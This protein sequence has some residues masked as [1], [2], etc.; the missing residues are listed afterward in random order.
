MEAVSLT[1]DLPEVI[2][3][4]KL[5]KSCLYASEIREKLL[6]ECNCTPANVPTNSDEQEVGNYLQETYQYPE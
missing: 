2:E 1:V 5:Q 6:H 3:I 4:W